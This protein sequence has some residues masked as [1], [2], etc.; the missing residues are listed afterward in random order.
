M[1]IILFFCAGYKDMGILKKP[2]PVKYFIAM[3]TGDQDLFLSCEKALVELYG[4][5]DVRSEIVPWSHSDYY[6]TEMGPGLFRKFVCLE[7]LGTPDQLPLVKHDMIKLEK[8]WSSRVLGAECRRINID[9]GYLTEAK[10]VLATTKDFAHRLYIGGNI[11][12]ELELTYRKDIP[13]F[14][15]L[16]HTYPDYRNADTITWFNKVRELLRASLLSKNVLKN[17]RRILP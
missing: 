1:C 12:A 10:V 6:V 13:G 8:R 5:V 7:Q 14:V 4:P 9:P 17:D 16:E 11:Y 3:L 15:P 2:L